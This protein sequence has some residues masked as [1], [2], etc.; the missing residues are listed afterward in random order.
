MAASRPGNPRKFRFQNKLLSMDATVIDLCARVFDGARFR[1]TQGAVKLHW[2]LDHDGYL[3]EYAV[4]TE[5]KRHA[6]RVARQMRFTPG[7]RLVF[8]RGYADYEWFHRLG[9]QQVHFVT[10]LKDNADYG[11]VEERELPRRKGVRRDQ[12]IFFYKLGRESKECFFRRVEFWEEAQNRLL[13]FLTNP[14]TLSA[15]T[16]AALYKQRWAIELFFESST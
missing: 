6:V 12:V 10:R 16:I 7:T 8:D 1:P 3:P 4:I 13:V 11:V 14:M 9:Q 2:L 5:G 15:A